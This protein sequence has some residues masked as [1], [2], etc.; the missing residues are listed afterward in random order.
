MAAFLV[1]HGHSFRF[2]GVFSG[3]VF[4]FGGGDNVDL[5]TTSFE[6]DLTNIVT[7]IATI[8]IVLTRQD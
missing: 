2:R 6:I 8:L 5:Y 7:I 3:I 1:L 4:F